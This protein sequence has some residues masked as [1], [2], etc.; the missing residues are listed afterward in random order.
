MDFAVVQLTQEALWLMLLLSAPFIIGATIVGLLI[1]F[2]QAVTQL[3]E[4]TLG[5][6]AKLA[7]ISTLIFLTA[8]LVGE[9]LF[10]FTSRI[11]SSL[12]TL[13]GT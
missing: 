7:V 11:F 4:Q 9:T 13:V 12:P 8:G 5:F 1:A 2:F 3:Q 6:A 10:Q